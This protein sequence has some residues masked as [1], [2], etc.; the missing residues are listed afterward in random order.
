MPTRK[1]RR[2]PRS[3][4]DKVIDA[5]LLTLAQETGIP[6]DIVVKAFYGQSLLA[7]D[8]TRLLHACRKIILGTS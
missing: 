4:R 3:L 5:A 7:K 2:R 1:T 8:K 6:F